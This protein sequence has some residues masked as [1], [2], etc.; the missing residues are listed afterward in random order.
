MKEK[1]QILALKREAG[2]SNDNSY[3]NDTQ[4]LIY[5]CY[6]IKIISLQNSIMFIIQLWYIITDIKHFQ[7]KVLWVCI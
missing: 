2:I 6:K 1:G 4:S 7:T 3:Q 5:V